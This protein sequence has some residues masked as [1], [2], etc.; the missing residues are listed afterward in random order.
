MVRQSALGTMPEHRKGS[1]AVFTSPFN[2]IGHP[3]M[4][5]PS[6]FSASTGLPISLQLVGALHDEVTLFQFARALER[7]SDWRGRSVSFD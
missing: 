3:A 2:A 1:N 7:T 6:G 4:S 5:V